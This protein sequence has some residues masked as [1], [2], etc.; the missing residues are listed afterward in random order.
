M[1]LYSV[2]SGSTDN[3]IT[4]KNGK[5]DIG[6]VESGTSGKAHI[7]LDLSTFPFEVTPFK[8]QFRAKP[9]R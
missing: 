6:A 3:I 5:T 2:L 7:G 1:D 9:N 8:L 4:Y